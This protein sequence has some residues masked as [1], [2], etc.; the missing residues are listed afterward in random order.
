MGKVAGDDDPDLRAWFA[1]LDAATVKARELEAAYVAALP[2]RL[3]AAARE[4]NE[5]F[6]DILP[7]GCRFEW[8][9]S[10]VKQ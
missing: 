8:V 1:S 10:E 9:S 6:A 2:A 5:R 4:I 3:A 7:E